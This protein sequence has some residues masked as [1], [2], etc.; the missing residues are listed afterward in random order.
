MNIDEENLSAL[1]SL[2]LINEFNALRPRASTFG[3]RKWKNLQCMQVGASHKVR[4]TDRTKQEDAQRI[5]T[6]RGQ[7]KEN[8]R[9]P[10]WF[11]IELTAF[12]L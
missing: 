5:L 3:I 6:G 11:G 12:C 7:G 1:T 2:H 10:L 8:G 4:D 9:W